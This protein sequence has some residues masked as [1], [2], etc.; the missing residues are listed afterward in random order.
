M[1]LTNTKFC[2]IIIAAKIL[3]CQ[4]VMMTTIFNSFTTNIRGCVYFAN[5]TIKIKQN[6]VKTYK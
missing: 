5:T 1:Q 6:Y 4:L 2:F 3:H